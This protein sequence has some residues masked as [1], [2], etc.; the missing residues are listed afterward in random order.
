[1]AHVCIITPTG[2]ICSSDELKM[3]QPTGGTCK[4]HCPHPQAEKARNVRKGI[5]DAGCSADEQ[6]VVGTVTDL[7]LAA[8][9][10]PGQ[11]FSIVCPGELARKGA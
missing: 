4:E 9:V 8:G 3:H 10:K 7:M 11:P 2:M 1:M 5:K 6:D